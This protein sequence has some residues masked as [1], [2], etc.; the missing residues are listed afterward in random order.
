MRKYTFLL[1]HLDRPTETLVRFI[2]SE[3]I[4]TDTYNLAKTGLQV[5]QVLEGFH[6][7]LK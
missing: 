6:Y 5:L 3:D 2:W 4:L 1:R 7:Q